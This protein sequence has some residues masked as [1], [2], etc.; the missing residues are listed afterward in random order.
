MWWQSGRVP[1]CRSQGPRFNPGRALVIS[2]EAPV[3]FWVILHLGVGHQEHWKGLG[4]KYR[5][6]SSTRCLPHTIVVRVSTSYIK[7]RRLAT[8]RD[9]VYRTAQSNLDIKKQLQSLAKHPE[10]TTLARSEKCVKPAHYDWKKTLSNIINISWLTAD[11][12]FCQKRPKV[13][14]SFVCLYEL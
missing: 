5:E 7:Q 1:V 14:L 13:S 2:Y 10:M 6:T 11:F 4:E 3:L 9:P 8:W 12:R